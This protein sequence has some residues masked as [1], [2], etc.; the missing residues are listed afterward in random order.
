MAFFLAGLHLLLFHILDGKDVTAAPANIRQ[1]DVTAVS[2]L[3]ATGFRTAIA[4]SIGISIT[5]YLWHLFRRKALE[6]RLI[7]DLFQ[8][9]SNALGLINPKIIQ[10]AP[11]IFLAVLISWLV[12]VATI[13][14]PS[15]LTIQMKARWTLETVNASVFNP[16]PKEGEAYFESREGFP[17]MLNYYPDLYEDVLYGFVPAL[18]CSTI[19][20][21]HQGAG[22]SPRTAYEVCPHDRTSDAYKAHNERELVVPSSI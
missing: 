15:A 4:S 14:P 5:Q 17:A 20:K 9:R 19:A 10:H 7:E 18:P 22:A 2:L 6:I 12:P 1:S 11:F 21:R 8:I 3:L 13:Y 16:A